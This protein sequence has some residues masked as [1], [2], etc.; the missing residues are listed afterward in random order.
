MKTINFAHILGNKP[1][2]EDLKDLIQTVNDSEKYVNTFNPPNNSSFFLE[3]LYIHFRRDNVVRIV[4]LYKPRRLGGQQNRKYCLIDAES[5][6]FNILN[7]IKE[8]SFHF[9]GIKLTIKEENNP[10]KNYED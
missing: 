4:A 10:V 1:L 5:Q 3:T 7:T 8:N 9:G 2:N 6:L